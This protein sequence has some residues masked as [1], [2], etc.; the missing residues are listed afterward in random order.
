MFPEMSHWCAQRR[1]ARGDPR[2][3]GCPDAW[4]R[5]LSTPL[6]GTPLAWPRGRGER[7]AP[8]NKPPACPA[9]LCPGQSANASGHLVP[10][11]ALLPGTPADLPW[12]FLRPKVDYKLN[13]ESRLGPKVFSKLADA[14]KVGSKVAPKPACAFSR[15]SFCWFRPCCFRPAPAPKRPQPQIMSL[16]E[17]ADVPIPRRGPIKPVAGGMR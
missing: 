12:I 4:G 6:P 16:A 9:T 5:A 8:T 10:S 13:G 14:F 11:S 1:N 15:F 7:L 2:Y 3:P 17:C